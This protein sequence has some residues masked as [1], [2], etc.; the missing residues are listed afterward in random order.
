[1][2]L[3]DGGV[4]DRV[5]YQEHLYLGG[6]FGERAFGSLTMPRRYAS[7]GDEDVAFSSGAALSDLSGTSSVLVAGPPAPA[8]VEAAF[9]G[10]RLA[11]GECAFEAVLGGDGTLMSIPLLARTGDAE[12]VFWDASGRFELLSGWLGFLAD[13]SQDGYAPYAGLDREDVSG[14]LVPLLLW[15]PAAQHVLSDY[16]EA[17]VTLPATGHVRDVRLDRI[18]AVVAAPPVAG[19]RCYLTLVPPDFARTLWRSFLSFDEVTP[20]GE[21]ALVSH[22]E[23]LLGWLP[24]VEDTDRVVPT[25]QELERW[26]LVRQGGGFVGARAI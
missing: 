5:L 16:L 25:R 17:G 24:W 11:V 22:A 18:P 21:T 14:R 10:R 4:N 13:V 19:G 15:G 7:E 1:M 3:A 23:E 12:Y 8:F 26:G 9:S 6:T 2:S 20:V